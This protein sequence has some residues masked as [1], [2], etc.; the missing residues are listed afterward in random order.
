[1]VKRSKPDSTIVVTFPSYS[2]KSQSPTYNLFC[3]YSLIKYSSWC[4]EDLEEMDNE[5]D[6]EDRSNNFLE[7][8]DANLLKYCREGVELRRLLVEARNRGD[9][10][11]RE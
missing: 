5:D 10:E 6:V 2:G 1:M 8:A 9:Y 3:K 11:L 7:K 4:Y